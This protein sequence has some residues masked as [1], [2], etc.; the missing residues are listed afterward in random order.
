MGNQF[1][2]AVLLA[3]MTAFIMF[4]GQLLG[5][6]QGMIIALM[7]AGGMNF[8]N[9]ENCLWPVPKDYILRIK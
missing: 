6:R 1:R 8:F 2:T 9:I 3:V 7:F 4:V 5:G